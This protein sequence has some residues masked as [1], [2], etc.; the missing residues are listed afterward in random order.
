VAH[1]LAKLALAIG[2]KHIWEEDYPPPIHDCTCSYRASLGLSNKNLSLDF[3]LNSILNHTKYSTEWAYI[4]L[5][6]II[7]IIII[8]KRMSLYIQANNTY[9]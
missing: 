3:F 5:I 6:I 4:Y 8:I 9:M 7:I 1:R 2:N